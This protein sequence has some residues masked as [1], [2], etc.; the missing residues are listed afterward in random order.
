MKLTLK[1][2]AKKT[3][4]TIGR[5][6]VDDVRFCD[7]LEDTDRGLKQT[8]S[9]ASIA[10]RKVYG[11]TAIPSGT[12]T[13]TMNVVSPKYAG[14]DWYKRNCNGGRMPRLLRVPGYEGVLIHPGNTALDAL[15][16]VLVGQNKQVGRLINSRD[17][18][19]QLYK[20]MNDAAKRGESI[21]LTIE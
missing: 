1:R 12:Y 18:F 14:V 8:D 10:A 17:T 15:G 4:Y 3:T 16:C 13:V 20:K 6:F 7:T 21:T 5:L 2:I 11:E 19:A 9:P